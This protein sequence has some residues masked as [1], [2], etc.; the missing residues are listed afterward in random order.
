MN[1]G[2]T[3][4]LLFALG[5]ILVATA[6]IEHARW[7]ARFKRLIILGLWLRVVGAIVYLYFVE[8]YYGAGDYNHYFRK[9]LEYSELLFQ[10][11]IDAFLDSFHGRWWG[12]SFMEHFTGII[13][14]FI[15][16]SLSGAF[17]VCAALS[18]AGIV[19]IVLGF[20][21]AF[22]YADS[23]PFNIMVILFPSLWFW[24][25]AL[26]KDALVLCG[27][28]L[29]TYGY[30]GW[31]DRPLWF[32]LSVGIGLIFC[33]RPQVAATI[34][35]A[36]VA[37]FW[38]GG[39][40]QWTANRVL[41]GVLLLAAGIGVITLSG[42]ALGI[43]MFD[44]DQVE[45]YLD[46]ESSVSTRGGSAIEG[47]VTPW[48][49]PIN[50]L[51]RPFPW[52]AGSVTSILAAGEVVILWGMAWYRRRHIAAFV[53]MHRGSRLFWMA[54]IFVAVYSTAMGMAI[55]N[56]GIIARQ[57]VHVLP[58]LLMFIAGAPQKQAS[59]PRNADRR[60]RLPHKT[61]R[62]LPQ[63]SQMPISHPH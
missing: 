58:F 57:R 30:I 61:T 40:R 41:Q 6:L 13:L 52:E 46:R 24:P 27:V 37:G 34:V 38:L 16:P 36:F 59:P 15:G 54:L 60:V 62:P 43:E 20:A 9:G 33:I 42:G 28:G 26:G 45:D 47:S 12:T 10:D 39:S 3:L 2:S 4:G 53:R 55:G 5:G 18:Y 63:P 49:A 8:S 31:R 35:F 1:P 50:T 48:L 23:A 21:R 22:P 25:A 11:G 32:P 7:N 56:I 29:A 44:P 14:S 51:F 19:G 17:V